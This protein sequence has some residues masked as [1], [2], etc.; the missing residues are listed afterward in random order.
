MYPWNAVKVCSLLVHYNNFS[1][2]MED[3]EA[4]SS[5]KHT[6][7]SKFINTFAVGIIVGILQR[8][9]GGR[10]RERKWGKREKAEDGGGRK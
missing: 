10:K 6:S 3:E 8:S 1:N 7:K 9:R 2:L 4:P 5:C